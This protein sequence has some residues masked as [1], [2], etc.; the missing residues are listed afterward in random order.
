MRK[1]IPLVLLALMAKVAA[2][3]QPP[4]APV[5][6][7]VAVAAKPTGPGGEPVSP[8][9]KEGTAAPKESPRMTRLKQLAF[10]RRPSAVL[11][12]WAPKPKDD[13]PRATKD[14][15]EE[16]LD[17]ELSEFQK[18]VT[19]GHWP[20][21]KNYMATLPDEESIA[22]YSRML[23]NLLQRPGMAGPSPGGEGPMMM[24][25]GP[26]AA[27][28]AEKNTFTPEDVIGLAA[29]APSG[30]N[31]VSFP[32]RAA[33]ASS[34]A[35]LARAPA[36]L[37]R[38]HLPS[39][40]GILRE[41]VAGGTLAEVAVARLGTEAAK[42]APALSRRQVA[43]VLVNAGLPEFATSRLST[44]SPGTTSR[45]TPRR[46]SPATWR[47]RGP[48][49]RPSWLHRPGIARRRKRVC[50]ARSSSRPG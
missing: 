44:C 18:H 34:T 17:K 38:E 15:K 22:A 8:D 36:G 9:G 25:G 14:P 26:A 48:R 5:P 24:P 40:A 11:K 21:V 50:S 4:E 43:R 32:P 37:T 2:M 41:T 7:P 35:V 30:T 29:A 6:R 42:P 13:K 19:M 20:A 23:Q 12:A 27:Q 45:C 10:D 49:R 31:P 47:R 39:L 46:P 3:A 28:F 1:Y 33:V 16:A